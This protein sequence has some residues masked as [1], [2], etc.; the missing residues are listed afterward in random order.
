MY[1]IVKRCLDFV[2]ALIALTCALPLML[3]I[4][5][6]LRLT[7]GSPVLFRQR[8]PGLKEVP[9]TCLKFRTMAEWRDDEG[10]L[11]PDQQRLT[12]IGR[13]LRRTSLDELPQFFNIVKGDLSFVGPRPLLE[14]Y[15]P[16]Y[17]AEE[18]RR[19]NVRP[20]LTG[21]AQI[22]GRKERTF[23]ERFAYDL[24]YVENV[25]FRLDMEILAR[26]FWGLFTQKAKAVI[27]DEPE[28]ALDVLRSGRP[29]AGHLMS[30]Q[31]ETQ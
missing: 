30:R 7:L 16:Y 1:R 5:I 13:F 14:S 21:W 27:P 19:H 8:R 28:I 11:L 12:R 18:R 15:T 31:N 24:C 10:R 9:F 20:G 26:T 4:A 17:T 29:Y 25:S 23:E 3:M 2:G 6:A 22:H